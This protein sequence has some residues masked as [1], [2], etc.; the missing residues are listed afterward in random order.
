M[1]ALHRDM[2][3]YLIAANAKDGE[4]DEDSDGEADEDGEVEES[5]RAVSMKR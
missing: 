4:F 5:I 2:N 1:N 3:T